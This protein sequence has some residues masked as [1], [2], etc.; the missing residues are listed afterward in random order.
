MRRNRVRFRPTVDTLERR[1]SAAG[2]EIA[3][4]GVVETGTDLAVDREMPPDMPYMPPNTDLQPGT[5]VEPPALT[6][7]DVVDYVVATEIYGW[8]PGLLGGKI[9]YSEATGEPI[10]YTSPFT[11]P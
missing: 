11:L 9:G 10:D 7:G 1:E 4:G 6:V 5:G 3:V 2:V 8:M